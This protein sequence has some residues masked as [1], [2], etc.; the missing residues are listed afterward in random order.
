MSITDVGNDH[1]IDGGGGRSQPYFRGDSAFQASAR[2][3]SFMVLLAPHEAL[4]LEAAKNTTLFV[5]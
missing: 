4:P 5:V 2:L 1:V 3:G